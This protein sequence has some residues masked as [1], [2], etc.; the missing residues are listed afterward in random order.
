MFSR[1]KIEAVTSA[2]YAKDLVAVGVIMPND[3]GYVHWYEPEILG[4]DE[5][6]EGRVWRYDSGISDIVD[7]VEES[8]LAEFEWLDDPAITVKQ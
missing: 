5:S 2:E 6:A 8:K 7:M 4:R 1:F 3:V